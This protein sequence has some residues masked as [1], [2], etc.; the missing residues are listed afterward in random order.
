MFGYKKT[1]PVSVLRQGSLC[2]LRYMWIQLKKCRVGKKI[3]SQ[4]NIL[5][6]FLHIF[7]YFLKIGR[8]TFLI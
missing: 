6:T 1:Q 3:K 8:R 7:P 5:S 2:L 4:L